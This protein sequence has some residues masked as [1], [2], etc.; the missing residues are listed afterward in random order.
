MATSSTRTIRQR[1]MG[2]ND[3]ENLNG[4]GGISGG[5]GSRSSS[6]ND[7]DGGSNNRFNKLRSYLKMRTAR[8]VLA[9]IVVS[10]GLS[11]HA[12]K[13]YL[14]MSTPL[15]RATK[16]LLLKPEE[17][18]NRYSASASSSSSIT[19]SSAAA[20]R[21]TKEDGKKFLSDL[22]DALSEERLQQIAS[23]NREKYANAKP[24]PHIALDGLFP[25]ELLLQVS[26]EIPEVDIEKGGPCLDKRKCFHSP[27]ESLKSFVDDEH[28]MGIYTI[29]FF[30]EF[31]RSE[32]WGRFLD[33]LTGIQGVYADPIYFGSGIHSTSSGGSLDV[34][35]DFNLHPWGGD[36]RVNTFVYLNDDPWPE[37]YGGHLELW[38][39]EMTKC[40]QRILPTF[41]RYV[42][43]STT[44]FSYHGHP[45]PLTTPSNR[46]RKSL[47]MYYYTNGRP[48]EECINNH[49]CNDQRFCGH[50]TLWQQPKG[51]DVC[52][53]GT[54][55]AYPEDEA[56]IWVNNIVGSGGYSSP[57][58]TV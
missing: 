44:D 6:N 4:K 5:G 56:P 37:E 24:F 26:N 32:K 29:L 13:I 7:D 10:V 20:V 2:C 53:H 54:C 55:K 17:I 18:E 35:S 22:H 43:F 23:E 30:N 49:C 51:C 47:A 19:S 36:R 40:E 58:V 27:T 3:E 16:N 9:T 34:H 14:S 45:Q 39:R 25:K 15:L 46:S 8:I 48:N 41:G 42:V 11:Y 28:D 21:I 52:Q 50:G 31:L 38:N 33:S 12:L 57:A 1:A